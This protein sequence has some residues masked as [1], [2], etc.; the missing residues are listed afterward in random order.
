MP[1]QLSVAFKTHSKLAGY[2]LDTT[3]LIEGITN[4]IT[5]L[6]PLLQLLLGIFA[7]LGFLRLFM[8][9]VDFIEDR[10]EGKS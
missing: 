6:P 8:L 2:S 5:A 7:T 10:R 9:V 4:F 1:Q 3:Q